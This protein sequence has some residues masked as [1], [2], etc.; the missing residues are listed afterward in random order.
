MIEDRA[1]QEAAPEL[2]PVEAR[3][4]TGPRD[5]FGVLV[6]SLVLAGVAGAVM[7]AYLLS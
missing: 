1:S 3:Q 2:T 6:V 5:T 7:L 4:G